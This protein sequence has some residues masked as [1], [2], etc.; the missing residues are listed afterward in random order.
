MGNRR[1]GTSLN[2]STPPGRNTRK[3]SAK[4]AAR[5]GKWNAASTLITP[6]NRAAGN[7]IR[8][9]SP[10]TPCAPTEASRSRPARSCDHVTLSAVRLRAPETSA[11]TG[12]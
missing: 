12:S 4:N 7:G 5:D 6:S 8:H 9:A 1:T 10:F 11:M 3:A 2:V